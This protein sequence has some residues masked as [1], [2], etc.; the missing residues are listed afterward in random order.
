[1]VVLKCLSAKYWDLASSRTRARLGMDAKSAGNKNRDT[2]R[3]DE[4]DINV[5]CAQS[6]TTLGLKFVVKLG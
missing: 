5:Q 1:M 3:P 2:D 6:S 4:P